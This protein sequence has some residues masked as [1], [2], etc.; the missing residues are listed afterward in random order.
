MK[1]NNLIKYGLIVLIAS[2]AMVAAGGGQET[3]INN[4]GA[5][6]DTMGNSAGRGWRHHRQ[7]RPAPIQAIRRQELQGPSDGYLLPAFWARTPGRGMSSSTGPTMAAS[8]R[9]NNWKMTFLRQNSI[10]V[11]VWEIPFE[12]LRW[13]MLTNLSMDPFE[14]A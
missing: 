3:V 4:I 9:Y 14:R 8:L 5:H 12:E 13:P 10:G 11:K 2:T 7:G 1:R 6:E